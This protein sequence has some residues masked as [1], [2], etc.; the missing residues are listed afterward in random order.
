MIT[1]GQTVTDSVTG[2][3]GVVVAK[4]QYLTGCEQAC[5]QPKAKDGA[6]VDSRWFDEDRLEVEAGKPT[7]ELPRRTANGC[8]VPPP[9]C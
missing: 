9:R 8:D 2:F 4:A 7:V 5:L 1:L 6:F 3:Q